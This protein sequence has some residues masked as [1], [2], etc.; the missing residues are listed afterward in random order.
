[1]VLSSRIA[2]VALTVALTV[3]VLVAVLT[4]RASAT[5]ERMAPRAPHTLAASHRDLT[6]HAAAR[7][8]GPTTLRADRGDMLAFGPSA[9]APAAP[10]AVVYLHGRRGLAAKGCPWL[11]DGAT[12]LGWLVCPTGVET[13]EHGLSSWGADL[14][15]QRDVIEDAFRAA[16]RSGAA[17][18][19]R[20][21]VGFSQGSH[22]AND[23]VRCGLGRFTGLV[24]LGADLH[25]SPERLRAAGVR[26]VVLGAGSRDP[27]F[28]PAKEEAARLAGL[29]VD[30]RFVDLGAVG[31]TYAAADEGAL[32]EAIRWAGGA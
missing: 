19:R 6:R 23:L 31:H 2:R 13:D 32:A 28:A 3:L 21:A 26:R 15:A 20:V 7:A 4:R 18:D 1:M 14:F 30:A 16:V 22:V 8:S 5:T 27:A 12:D 9:H 25:A 24:L 11:R 10:V 17:A 29:G